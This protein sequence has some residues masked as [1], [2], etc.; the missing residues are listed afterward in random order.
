MLRSTGDIGERGVPAV[1]VR[2]LLSPT[3]D[4]LRASG[5]CQKDS[6]HLSP[7]VPAATGAT[8]ASRALA[9]DEPG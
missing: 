9:G 1:R 5:P 3:D 8:C 4:A 2:P 6:T 7:H